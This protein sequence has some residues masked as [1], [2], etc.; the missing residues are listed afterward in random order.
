[1]TKCS[2]EY[3]TP[4]KLLVQC[5]YETHPKSIQLIVI[6]AVLVAV[7]TRT[8]TAASVTKVYKNVFVLIPQ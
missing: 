4:L 2:S 6:N 8:Y 7:C 5:S 3:N 1:M